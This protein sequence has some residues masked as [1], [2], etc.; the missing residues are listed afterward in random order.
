[1][2]YA[3]LGQL[4]RAMRV[5]DMMGNG[6]F[7]DSALIAIAN[8]YAES[9]QFDRA[10]AINNQI[11][12]TNFKPDILVFVAKQYLDR[13]EREKA[14]ALLRKAFGASRRVTALNLQQFARSDVALLF[15]KAGQYDQAIQIVKATDAQAPK[16]RLLTQLASVFAQAGKQEAAEKL[17]S[18]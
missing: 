12:T 11:E 17:L 13:G 6:S 18:E 10:L 14:I 4:E 2:R 15:A 3:R 1:K 16:L 7:K 8:K 9:G 5:S